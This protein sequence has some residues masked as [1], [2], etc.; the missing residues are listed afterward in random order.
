MSRR[1]TFTKAE[2]ARAVKA[3][4]DAGESVE[5]VEIT[6]GKIIVIAGKPTGQGGD[7]ANEWDGVLK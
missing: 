5:R 3:M 4:K 6:D 7:K 1:A 2:L